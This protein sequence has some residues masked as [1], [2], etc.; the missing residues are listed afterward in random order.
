MNAIARMHEETVRF[1]RWRQVLTDRETSVIHGIQQGLRNKQIAYE[2]RISE[3]TVKVH[4]RNIMRKLGASNRT[5]A[6]F[7]ALALASSFTSQE[8]E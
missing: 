5:D 7:K 4:I 1:S 6:A 2:L 8:S 3:N